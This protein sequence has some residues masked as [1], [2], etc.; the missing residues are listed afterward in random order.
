MTMAEVVA[1]AGRQWKG[2]QVPVMAALPVTVVLDHPR[3][4]RSVE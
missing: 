1:R 3:D 2:V 4:E